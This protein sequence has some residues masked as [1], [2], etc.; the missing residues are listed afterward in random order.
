MLGGGGGVGV[1][2]LAEDVVK[3]RV[4]QAKAMK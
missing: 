2:K 3:K 1:V 4:E